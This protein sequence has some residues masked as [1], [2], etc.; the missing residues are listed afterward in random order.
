LRLINC[1]KYGQ[2]QEGISYVPYP[3]ELGK[4][5]HAEVSQNFWKE[6]LGYQVMFINEN[7]LSPINPKDRK[8]IE[9]AMQKFFF[10]GGVEA[11]EGYTPE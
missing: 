4:R 9:E 1:I 3:G 8:R 6:W 5:I 10:D 11:V 7:R 2:D